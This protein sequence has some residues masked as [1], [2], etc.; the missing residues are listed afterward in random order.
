MRNSLKREVE[1][2]QRKICSLKIFFSNL[3]YFF[4]NKNKSK[5][6]E[7]RKNKNYF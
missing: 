4:Q 7:F 3:N 1:H 5:N 2:E 6:L